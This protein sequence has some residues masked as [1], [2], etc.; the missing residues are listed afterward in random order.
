MR[1]EIADELGIE[2]RQLRNYHLP[3]VRETDAIPRP[4]TRADCLE[5]P[6]PC[7]FATC[8]YHMAVEVNESTGNLTLRFPEREAIDIPET[9][10][11]DVADRGGATLEEVAQTM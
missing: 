8:R 7:P 3:I 4:A 11:L 10:S 6:R 5:M 2:P 1:R 9:C